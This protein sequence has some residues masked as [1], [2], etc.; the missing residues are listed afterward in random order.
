MFVEENCRRKTATQ[1]TQNFRRK[2]EL[3]KRME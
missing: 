1:H 3:P 2:C